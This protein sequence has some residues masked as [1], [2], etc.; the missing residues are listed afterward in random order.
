MLSVRPFDNVK[1]NLIECINELVYFT[2]CVLFTMTDYD[3]FTSLSTPIIYL[4]MA[5][6]FVTSIIVY[7]DM[8]IEWVKKC[9]AR[10]KK[11]ASKVQNL[12]IDTEK[13]EES[14]EEMN[15]P[16]TSRQ[17]S[18]YGISKLICLS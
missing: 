17:Y 15:N 6:T 5:G 3:Q 13:N 18:P 14:K 2:A 1:D 10:R 16:I 8:I 7:A 4:I 9:K 11:K 12:K